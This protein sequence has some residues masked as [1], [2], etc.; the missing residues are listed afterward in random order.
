MGELYEVAFADADH[1]WVV[2]RVGILH[3]TNGGATWTKVDGAPP[4]Y[5]GGSV[6]AA[7]SREALA[8]SSFTGDI[9]GTS[10]AISWENHRS[11]V[12]RGPQALAYPDPSTA[13]AVGNDGMILKLAIPEVTTVEPGNGS[14]GGGTVVTVT[15]KNFTSAVDVRFGTI[16]SMGFTV[17]SDTEIRAVA[18]PGV[19][20]GEVELSVR[21]LEGNRSP[22][23]SSSRFSYG[24]VDGT[25]VVTELGPLQGPTA[26][27]TTVVVRGSGLTGA[28]A[29]TFGA[30]PAAAFSVLSDTELNA[31]SPP[32]G[33]GTVDVTVTTPDGTTPLVNAARFSFVDGQ[34]VP[35]PAVAT[36]EP[37]SGPTTGGTL[38][39]LR[40]SGFTSSGPVSVRFG[41]SAASGVRMI[42]D[43]RLVA[44]S[45]PHLSGPVDVTVTA[46]AT[47]PTAPSTSFT[48]GAG[49]WS[50]TGRLD[51]CAPASAS[52]A[53]R[54][55][56]TATLLDGPLCRTATPPSHCGKVLIAGGT[57]SLHEGGPLPTAQ[58]F[59]AANGTWSATGSMAT[60]RLF[61]TAAALPDGRVIVAG[62]SATVTRGL[63]STEVYDP[64][65][66]AWSPGPSLDQPRFS[67]TSTT[68][69]E[70]GILVVG[71][72]D[73]ENNG[74]PPIASVERLG[75]TAAGAPAA[76][77]TVPALDSCGAG[78][79]SCVA[80][81]NHTATPLSGG[82]VLVAGGLGA[83]GVLLGS[84]QIYDPVT[85]AGAGS[86]RPAASMAVAR[87]SHTATILPENSHSSA[88]S[89]VLVAGGVLDSSGPDETPVFTSSA[90][91]FEDSGD[92]EGAWRPVGSMRSSRAGHTATRISDGSVLV[93]GSSMVFGAIQPQPLASAKVYDPVTRRWSLTS[94]MEAARGSHTATV[95]D[96]PGC[97]AGAPP[98]WCGDVMVVGGANDVRDRIDLS[99]LP[100]AEIYSTVPPEIT[101]LAPAAGPS[102]GG[103]SVVVTGER[104]ASA[105]AVSFGGVPA[106]R[107]TVGADSQLTAV[108]PPHPPGPVTVSVTNAAGS[109]RASPISRF[110]YLASAP[111]G[112][113]TGL[114]AT[115]LSA[116]K[117]VLRFIAP[118]SDGDYPPP[119]RR[120]LVRQSRSPIETEAGF[121]AATPLCGGT[122]EFVPAK[123][124]E[125]LDLEVV[126]L[127]PAT[128]YHYAVRALND[129][130][131]L[132][133]LSEDVS[134]TTGDIDGTIKRLPCTGA[135]EPGP[136]QVRFPSGYS[137]AGFPQGTDPSGALA[138]FGWFDA[139]AGSA[140][141]SVPSADMVPGRGYW[142]YFPCPTTVDLGHSSS[143]A[144][145]TLG[146]YHA[147]IVGNPSA[148]SPATVSGHDFTA[149]WVPDLA[150]GAG[151]YEVS[152]YRQPQ[153]MPIG[154][155]VWVFSFVRTEVT[156]RA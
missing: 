71:G 39:L 152:T 57:T 142:V 123:V 55:H 100:L 79:D 29:V 24:A 128:T 65:T 8:T 70:G 47:S 74:R 13:F 114:R 145:S 22:P 3:T 54:Y 4:I 108:T 75:L 84:A 40:G 148:T 6:A 106:L 89:A 151:G 18:P 45:P 101:G 69:P 94:F 102:S 25:P 66:G 146:E 122:C 53:G 121:E 136:G 49:V 10:D 120:Y 116:S 17:V 62:G 81:T 12:T 98:R 58:L 78:S 107:F 141:T 138:L 16:A 11:N 41:E 20:G 83:D 38:V 48:Y 19:A 59:D 64:G 155:A 125:D 36:V 156:V 139:G 105:T 80:R 127:L 73:D 37:P 115:P 87:F 23:S 9:R 14:L 35:G 52:C 140:Y 51:A 129:A 93:A 104:L 113:V 44:V 111:P 117:V 137:L 85:S 109:S 72:T 21:G 147:S 118:A 82:R 5:P 88:S 2:G 77:A 154:T 149:R 68:L 134:V 131:L 42:S 119:A 86:W 33:P 67:H 63:S 43:E 153:T 15:G 132:G 46:R 92:G 135:P 50:P 126:D 26:G 91:V 90:E 150:G 1:G 133:P 76:W 60:P 28:S 99:P 96:G 103:T 32:R 27:E 7:G 97:R 30:T 56:H 31:V 95:L 130:Q 143:S 34:T 124:G 110:S 112:V 61:H 144:S